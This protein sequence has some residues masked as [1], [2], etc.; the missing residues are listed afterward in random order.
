MSIQT[1]PCLDGFHQTITNKPKNDGTKYVP[2][3]QQQDTVSINGG[4]NAHLEFNKD[5]SVAGPVYEGVINGKNTQLKMFQTKND[6]VYAEGTIKDKALSFECTEEGHRFTGTYGG[7]EFDLKVDYNEP[8]KI[9]NFFYHT[10]M[11][12][13]FNIDYFN[14]SGKI[15]DKEF[16]INLPNAKVPKDEE[17]KDLLSTML[18]VNGFEALTYNDNII[19]FTSSNLRR[20]DIRDDK[21]RRDERFN[22]DIKPLITNAVTM[23][24]SVLVSTAIA[25]VLAKVGVKNLPK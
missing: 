6:N 2:Q 11:G 19:D 24:S 16:N 4:M 3:V 23:I 7:K 8:S 22:E 18:F 20:G 21:K 14:V 25:T 5:L 12:R 1:T 17:Q 10:I 15:G 9:K 13:H